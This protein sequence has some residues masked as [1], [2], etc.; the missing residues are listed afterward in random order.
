MVTPTSSE[1][2]ESI[3]TKKS[4]ARVWSILEASAYSVSDGFGLRNITPY[5]LALNASNSMV[6]LLTS[7]PSL[8]GNLIQLLTYKLMRRYSRKT[9]VLFSVFLQ[10][11]F[12]LILLIP[13]LLFLHLPTPHTRVLT[14]FL[15][16]YTGLIVSG[17]V[18]GPAWS[19]WMKDIVPTNQLGR[20]FARRGKIAGAIAFVSTILAGLI[21]DYFKKTELLYGFFILI[22]FSFLFRGIS[23]CLFIKQYEPRLEKNETSYFSFIQ[24]LNNMP[25]NNF[26][27]F[28]IFL[29]LINLSVAICGPFF[30][31]YLLK[32]RAFSYSL[33]TGITMI[34]PIASILTMNSWGKF[35][36]RYGNTK[37][38]K[39]TGLFIVLIPFLYLLS[40]LFSS[41]AIVLAILIFT[42]LFGGISWG[43]FNL[44]ASNFLFKTVSREKIALCSAYM[45]VLTGFGIFAGATLGGWVSSLSFG[46]PLFLVFLA[47][48]IGRL[49]VYLFV[50]PKIKESGLEKSSYDRKDFI[51]SFFL[52]PRFFNQIEEINYFR[53][54]I[55]KLKSSRLFSTL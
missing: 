55:A 30:A 13:G 54:T 46:Y 26:G 33:Y 51:T 3:E 41:I 12:W 34:M 39:I 5:A 53:R 36:D 9:I 47:S 16:I 19:S 18:A 14:L 1:A 20:Y 49:L 27:R 40:G 28:V 44:S 48:G 17:V 21:L 15:V 2:E 31:V 4:K 25:F 37:V 42:E 43:G 35:S 10:T 50:L 8:I 11:F 45:N 24:F 29:S 32:E 22:F 7:V 38:L 52:L 23:G 6:G